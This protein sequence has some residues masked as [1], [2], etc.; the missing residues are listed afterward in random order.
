[1]MNNTIQQRVGA[2]IRA[3]RVQRGITGREVAWAIGVS[4]Q[5]IWK[6]EVGKSMI[7]VGTITSIAQFLRMPISFFLEDAALPFDMLTSS[8]KRVALLDAYNKLDA[9][10]RDL[11]ISIAKS[12]GEARDE[13]RLAAE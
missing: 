7:S 5:Q 10:N 2:R 9:P 3:A 1:V 8:S 11:L 6:Y 13:H 12:L 4:Y